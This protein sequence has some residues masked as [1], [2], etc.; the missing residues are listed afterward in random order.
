MGNSRTELLA[1]VSPASSNLEELWCRSACVGGWDG[2]CVDWDG[3]SSRGVMNEHRNRSHQIEFGGMRRG[4]VL[5]H[6]GPARVLVKR[7]MEVFIFVGE[8]VQCR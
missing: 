4:V 1:C 8:R 2:G 5:V 3:H 7:L 6:I